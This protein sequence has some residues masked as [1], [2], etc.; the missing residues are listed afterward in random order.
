M[1]IYQPYFFVLSIF[2]VLGITSCQKD[3]TITRPFTRLLTLPVTDLDSLGVS[4]N[5]EV[6]SFIDAEII[7]YGFI[8]YRESID[9]FGRFPEE[10]NRIST[11]QKLNSKRF[12]LRAVPGYRGGTF[13]YVRAYI[14]SKDQ[15]VYGE[16]KE[17]FVPNVAKPLIEKVLPDKLV[18]GDTMIIIGKHF[19]GVNQSGQIIIENFSITLVSSTENEIQVIVPYYLPQSSSVMIKTQS[20][21]LSSSFPLPPMAIPEIETLLP[22]TATIGDTIALIGKYFSPI[23]DFNKIEGCGATVLSSSRDRIKFLITTLSPYDSISYV[24]LLVGGNRTKNSLPLITLK[25]IMTN[26]YPKEGTVGDTIMIVGDNFFPYLINTRV[27]FKNNDFTVIESSK[28]HLKAIVNKIPLQSGNTVSDK[29]QV[30][31]TGRCVESADL[32]T[33]IDK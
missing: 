31:L 15:V 33:Y 2:L 6:I 25:P 12:S 4:F 24:R 27:L 5:A 30:C 29:L 28:N 18:P 9:R 11:K 26:F 13:L 20:G 19:Y 17:F 32:F 21:N 3:D 22:N 23:P 14:K 8:W 16:E 7:E 1:K 10:F